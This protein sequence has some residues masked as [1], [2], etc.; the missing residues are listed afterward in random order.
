[1]GTPAE[2]SAQ[3]VTNWAEGVRPDSSNPRALEE[4]APGV[5]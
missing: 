5:D 3:Y 1:V 2:R 4:G